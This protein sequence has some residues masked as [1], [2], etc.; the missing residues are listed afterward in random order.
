MSLIKRVVRAAVNTL[1][2]DIR[3]TAHI[4]LDAINDMKAI[5]RGRLP[6]VIFDVGAHHGETALLFVENFPHA[7]IHSFE[8]GPENFIELERQVAKFPAVRTIHAALG[9]RNEAGTLNLNKSSA[10]N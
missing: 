1:G 8:P 10:T 6:Q 2:Y 7:Q 5:L 9:S 4:G 3:S